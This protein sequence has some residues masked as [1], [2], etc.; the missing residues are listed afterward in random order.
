MAKTARNKTVSA[1]GN[2]ALAGANFPTAAGLLTR[3]FEPDEL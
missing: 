3:S 2:I 1:R